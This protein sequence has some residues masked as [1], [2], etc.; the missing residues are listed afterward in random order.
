MAEE[1]V[2]T[3]A[4]EPPIQVT[5]KDGTVWSRRSLAN[6]KGKHA[7]VFNYLLVGPAN[8]KGVYEEVWCAR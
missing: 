3:L 8:E 4:K 5:L 6:G 1:L 7:W 2:P